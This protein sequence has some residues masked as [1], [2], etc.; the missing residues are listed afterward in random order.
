MV[1][2]SVGVL[3]RGDVADPVT[4]AKEAADWYHL[5]A[6]GECEPVTVPLGDP[7]LICET[8]EETSS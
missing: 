8:T 7:M 6:T 4:S 5:R 1:H 2:G 3:V